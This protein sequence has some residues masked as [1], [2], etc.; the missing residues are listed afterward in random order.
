MS[1]AVSFVVSSSGEAQDVSLNDRDNYGITLHRHVVV[2]NCYINYGNVYETIKKYKLQT[3]TFAKT[4]I[5]FVF[6]FISV[7]QHCSVLH[8]K[9]SCN[10]NMKL[11]N[12]WL[13]YII[14]D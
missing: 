5:R 12:I 14:T 3:I 4:F 11:N 2:P 6:S 9:L 13:K 7:I 1:S 10:D 8:I